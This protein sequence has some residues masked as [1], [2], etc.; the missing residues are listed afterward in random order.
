M[1]KKKKTATLEHSSRTDVLLLL[2]LAPTSRV[3][4]S[5]P[6]RRGQCRDLR[7]DNPSLAVGRLP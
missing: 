7:V 4:G 5:Q 3:H 1:R 6:N 2:L